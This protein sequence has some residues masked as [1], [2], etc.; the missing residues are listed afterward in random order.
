MY[1]THIASV[2]WDILTRG[3]TG[4]WVIVVEVGASGRWLVGGT[5]AWVIVN[6]NKGGQ[7]QSFFSS[8]QSKQLPVSHKAKA[9][10]SNN[11][12]IS[13]DCKQQENQHCSDKLQV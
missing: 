11:L 5:S 10:P 8:K 12:E 2:Q 6:F 4:A 3:G 13:R 9:L 1:A 7:T